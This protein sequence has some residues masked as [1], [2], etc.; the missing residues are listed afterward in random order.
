[1]AFRW[2]LMVLAL[3]AGLAACAAAGR[4]DPNTIGPITT[5]PVTTTVASTTVTTTPPT[6]T[7]TSTTTTGSTTSTTQA[8]DPQAATKQQI[9]DVVVEAQE[10]YVQAIFDPAGFDLTEL[11]QYY[12]DPK[13]AQL[14]ELLNELVSKDQVFKPTPANQEKVLVETVQMVSPAE[15]LAIVCV[16]SDSI[17]VDRTTESVLDDSVMS[18]LVSFNL[19][20]REGTWRIFE[21]SVVDRYPDQLSCA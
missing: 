17:R 2:I 21:S 6:T 8:Q 18:F 11:G 13:L 12:E 19:S 9:A 20:L 15:A 14:E 16:T 7:S 3:T 1:M 4:G 5:T 10:L